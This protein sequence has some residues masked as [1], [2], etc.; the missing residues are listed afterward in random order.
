MVSLYSIG[1][2]LDLHVLT[3]SYAPRRSPY[4]PTAPRGSTASWW[5]TS[6][7][8]CATPASAARCGRRSPGVVSG[9]SSSSPPGRRSEEHKSELQS[10]MRTSYAVFLM[11]KQKE[12]LTVTTHTVKNEPHVHD[13][14]HRLHQQ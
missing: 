5:P 11:K 4:L 7:S 13:L 12:K 10:L 3:H 14:A 8:R 2:H 1:D 6:P 9:S